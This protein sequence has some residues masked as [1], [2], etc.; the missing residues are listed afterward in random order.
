METMDVMAAGWTMLSL[1]FE[2]TESHLSLNI[3]TQE[4]ANLVKKRE[5][6]IKSQV[7]W[8]PHNVGAYI[9]HYSTDQSQ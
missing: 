5:E 1:I 4:E 8:T 2:I 6:T 3:P 7:S 9:M